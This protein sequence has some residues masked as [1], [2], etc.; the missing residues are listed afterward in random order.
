M[1]ASKYVLPR[2]NF[3]RKRIGKNTTEEVMVLYF[4]QKKIIV[5]Q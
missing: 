1:E 3:I 4:T 2:Y 5:L